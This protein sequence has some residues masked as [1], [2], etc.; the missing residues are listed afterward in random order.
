MNKSLGIVCCYFNPLNYQ[1]KYNNFIKFYNDLFAYHKD[2]LVVELKH[3]STLLT[4]PDHIQSHKVYCD[5][6]LWHKENL[7]NIGIS[8][9]IREGFKNIAWL[10]SD[11]IFDDSYWVQDCIELL[12]RVK[13]CQ[14]FSRVQSNNTFHNGCVREWKETGSILPVASAY[15]T[16]YGWAARSDVLKSCLLYDKSILGGADSLIWLSSFSKKY[17]FSEIIKHHPIKKLNLNDFFQDFLSWSE[18]WGDQIQGSVG[19]VYCPIKALSHGN[20]RDRN[21]ILRYQYLIDSNYNP[22]KDIT[23][24]DGIIYSNN[25]LLNTLCL[26]YFKSRNEDNKS[27]NFMYKITKAVYNRFNLIKSEINI[28]KKY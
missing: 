8:K 17:N 12:K 5:Q 19:H 7:L 10:D 21:Y 27:N 14:L 4:L 16:G 26:N 25:K 3:P 11:I 18:C 6:T 20:T 15:H 23:Y 28:A 2:V 9:L 24:K 1:S 13:L 22:K